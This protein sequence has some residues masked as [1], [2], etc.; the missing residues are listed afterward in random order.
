VGL[1]VILFFVFFWKNQV[2]LLNFK[3]C[4]NSVDIF[5]FLLYKIVIL[6]S[7]ID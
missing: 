4:N 7:R 1:I 2:F 5:D 3:E 6:I